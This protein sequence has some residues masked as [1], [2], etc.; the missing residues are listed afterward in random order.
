MTLLY[1]ED[2][3]EVANLYIR[4][5]KSKFKIVYTAHD[6]KKALELYEELKPDVVILD[7]DIPIM[8]GLNVAKKIRQRDTDTQLI[9]LT[10]A[11]DKETLF[12][13]IELGLT[14]Y[15]EKPVSRES[16]KIALNKLY[17]KT[18]LKLW[19]FEDK[20]YVWD[21][22]THELTCNDITIKLTKNEIK[23]FKLFLNKKNSAITYQDIYEYVWFENDNKNYSES[24]I[25]MLIAGLR[26][27]LPLN[28]IKNIYG[29]GYFFQI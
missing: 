6:G 8:S 13:A 16:L 7:I 1:V 17:L 21:I 14:T 19:I 3:L 15:L 11:S 12:Q 26:T 4:Y 23:L 2:E 10:A 20:E 22:Q 27:K 25:K 5:F 9:L 29:I 18:Q 24:A 28:I